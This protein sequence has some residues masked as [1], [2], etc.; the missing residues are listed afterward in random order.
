MVNSPKPLDEFNKEVCELKHTDIHNKI[1][2]IKNQIQTSTDHMEQSILVAIKQVEDKLD[3]K[4]FMKEENLKNKVIIVEKAVNDKIDVLSEFHEVLRG[5]GQPSIFELVR[6]LKFRQNIV[7]FIL[8]VIFFFM[9]AGDY[10]GISISK[11]RKFIGLESK[12]AELLSPSQP[13]ASPL[14]PAQSRLPS[15]L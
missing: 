14:D 13:S 11:I 9:I 1:S 8:V 2:D 4:L 5:N 3:S 7:L 15:S 10:R 6:T 12:Q